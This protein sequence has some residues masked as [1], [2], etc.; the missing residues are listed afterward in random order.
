MANPEH[1]ENSVP[2]CPPLE[3]DRACDVLD[4]HYRQIHNTTVVVNDRR[5]TIPVEVLIHA[6]LERCPGPLALGDLIYSTTLLPGEQVRLFTSDRRSRFTFDSATKVSYRNEQT[7][8][9]HFYMASMHDFMSD[10]TVRDSSRATNTS[11]GSAQGHGETSS[12]LGSIF[13]GPSVDVSGSYNAESTSEFLRELSQHVAA[14]DRRAE[15]GAR[16][17]ST[18]SIGEVQSRTHT[19]GESEDHF[20]SASRQF[21]NPNKCHAVT[22]FFY[23]INKTQTIKFAIESIERRIVDSAVD[24]K[25]ATNPFESRGDITAIPNSV[26]ATDRERLQV[27]AIGRASAVAQQQAVST[28]GGNTFATGAVAVLS[29]PQLVLQLEPLPAA[30][31][32]QALQQVDQ[33]LVAAG[34]LDK[35][36]GRIAAET[37]RRFSFERRTSLPTPGVLV[38]GCLDDC[39]ICEPTV[40]QEIELDLERKRLENERLKRII[41][42]MDKDQ[43][44]RCCPGEETST[45]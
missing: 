19:E 16:A 4:F 10:L 37:R 9:E 22:F 18:I 20:E 17:S 42:L 45:P 14:S 39:N 2:C 15:M 7:Q 31:R 23:R 43:E 5:Q 41:E 33:E 21:A 12:L 44:H 38:K 13:S 25:I 27:E 36:G 24:T 8:E 40:I 6:R 30:L 35:V 32:Q 3:T 28:A 11:R 1:T 26:L 29:R 34:L